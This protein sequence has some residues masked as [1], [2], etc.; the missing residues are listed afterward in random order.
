M[1][2]LVIGDVLLDIHHI[3]EVTRNA[4]EAN[5]PVYNTLHTEYRLGGAANVAKN[6]AQLVSNVEIISVIGDDESGKTIAH[7]LDEFSVDNTLHV[8]PLRKTT[9]KTRILH[10]GQIKARYDV[11]SKHSIDESI[12]FGLVEYVKSQQD[13]A[14]IVFSDYGKGMLTKTLC[15]S[16]IAYANQSNIL[17]FVDSKPTNVAKYAGCVC[18]KSNLPEGRLITGKHMPHDIVSEFK[19]LFFCQHAVLTCGDQ[20]MYIDTEHI[21]HKTALPVVDVTGS[22]D[23]VIAVLAHV[24][25]DTRDIQRAGRVANY[26]AGKGIGVMGNYTISPTDIEEY[27]DS[28]V[29][30]TEPDSIRRIRQQHDRVVFTNGCFDILHS[31]HIKLLQFA[32]RHG[33]VLVVGLNSDNSVKRLKGD[34]RPIQEEKERCEMLKHLGMVDYIVV[35]EDDTPAT[36]LSWLRPNIM[37]K[38]GDYTIETV[39]GREYADAVVLYGYESGKSTSNTIGKI[40][41]PAI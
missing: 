32:K 22:G 23:I 25:L 5:I 3:C 2:V 20:G 15:E 19:R 16:L 8:D 4:P 29:Y 39:I 10:D 30:D 21:R 26:I 18:F 13:I 11:E 6:M 9:Q 7:L 14:A 12:E 27:V 24:Y 37:I 38:G 17:T 1:R 41:R 31:A 36:I 34:S 33:G 35:F 28:V 40:L